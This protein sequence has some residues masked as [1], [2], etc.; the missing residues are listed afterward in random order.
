MDVRTFLFYP[1]FPYPL[2]PDR[3]PRSPRILRAS[4]V[5]GGCFIGSCAD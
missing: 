1:W 2:V 3:L 5:H 4:I